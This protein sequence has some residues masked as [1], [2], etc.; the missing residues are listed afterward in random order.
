MTLS[1]GVVSLSPLLGKEMTDLK[2]KSIEKKGAW[3]AQLGKCPALDLS[4][5]SR[6]L[7]CE[8]RPSVWPCPGYRAC[9]KKTKPKLDTPPA[10]SVKG[11]QSKSWTVL[12]RRKRNRGVW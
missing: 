7:V 1:L 10:Y 8:F 11:A 9:F 5:K 6:S 3:V 2:I 4:S 12:W